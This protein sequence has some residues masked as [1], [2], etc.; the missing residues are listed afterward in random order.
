MNKLGIGAIIVSVALIFLLTSSQLAYAPPNTPADRVTFSFNQASA[1]VLDIRGG[2]MWI[3]GG[4][5]NAAGGFN[6]SG[7]AGNWKAAKLIN[8][9]VSCPSCDIIISSPTAA[10]FE[11]VFIRAGDIGAGVSPIIRDVVVAT[12]DISS[13]NPGKNFWVEGFGFGTANARFH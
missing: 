5:I 12:S 6:D 3:V 8:V 11:G 9:A 1:G 4:S 7:T 2:G 13:S 10:V